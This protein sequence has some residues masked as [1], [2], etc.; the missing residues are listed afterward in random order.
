MIRN[1]WGADWG[2]DGYVYVERGYNLCGV[3]DEVTVPMVKKKEGT[4]EHKTK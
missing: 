3:S 4:N 2:E 1:S